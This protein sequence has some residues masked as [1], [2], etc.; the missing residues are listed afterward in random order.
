M[1]VISFSEAGEL[2]AFIQKHFD[3]DLHIHDTCAGQYFS[4]DEPHDIVREFLIAY[5]KKQGID[6]FISADGM[7]FFI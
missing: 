5:F 1:A 2:K 7:N 4:L 6:V 3:V